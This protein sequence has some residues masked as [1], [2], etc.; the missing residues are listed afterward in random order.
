MLGTPLALGLCD[1]TDEGLPDKLGAALGCDDGTTLSL[2]PC[3]D[4]G[5]PELVGDAL[6]C[7]LGEPETLGSSETT[8]DG[9]PDVDGE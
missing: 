9:D 8:D 6:G 7:E 1:G 2:G 3:V 4:E 5:I